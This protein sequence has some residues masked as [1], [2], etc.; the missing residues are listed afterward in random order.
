MDARAGRQQGD[1]V[2]VQ[3]DSR[4]TVGVHDFAGFSKVDMQN[5]RYKFVNFGAKTLHT[6]DVSA[7]KKQVCLIS[8]VDVRASRYDSVN[9]GAQSFHTR[10][11]SV[12]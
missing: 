2:L 11:A 9:F 3:G 7:S 4:E 8:R 12:S 10:G 1:R 6:R 5:L